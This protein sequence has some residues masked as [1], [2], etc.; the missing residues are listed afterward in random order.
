MTGVLLGGAF[1][2]RNNKGCGV[3]VCVCPEH[4]KDLV[5]AKP[6]NHGTAGQEEEQTAAPA[7]ICLRLKPFPALLLKKIQRDF[8]K[9]MNCPDK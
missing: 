4:L 7:S 3:F 2:F 6:T 8:T 9:T 5:W 1:L